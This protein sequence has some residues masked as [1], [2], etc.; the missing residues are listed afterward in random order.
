MRAAILSLAFLAALAAPGFAGE[1]Q[2]DNRDAAN[3]NW[4]VEIPLPRHDY[5]D[6]RPDGHYDRN[7]DYREDRD[8]D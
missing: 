6:D 4:R 7:G 5:R 3:P 1:R 8:D 2:H